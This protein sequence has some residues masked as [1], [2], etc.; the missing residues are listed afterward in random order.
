M[1]QVKCDKEWKIVKSKNG[2]KQAKV[3]VE[4]KDRSNNAFLIK[5]F[6][7]QGGS[8]AKSICIIEH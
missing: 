5:L 6:F 8:V 7:G 3:V 4:D 1:R 2:S